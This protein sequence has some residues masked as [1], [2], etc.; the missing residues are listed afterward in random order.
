MSTRVIDSLSRHAAGISR[1][2]SLLGLSITGIVALAGPISGEAK[3]DSRR[4]DRRKGKEKK[5]G[6]EDRC[7][8]Q[9]E[10]CIDFITA[11]CAGVPE[12]LGQTSCCAFLETCE[13]NTF[14]V[15]MVNQV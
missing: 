5:A 1:R 3:K 7:P 4:K 6:R 15:C 2:S 12:C 8:E 13:V 14:L 10:P 9:V 11:F